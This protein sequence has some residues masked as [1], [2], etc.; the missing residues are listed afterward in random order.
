[1]GTHPWRA[2]RYAC[3]RDSR[4]A[5]LVAAGT[6]AINRWIGSWDCIDRF[7]A[8]SQFV[9]SILVRAG[10]DSDRIRVKP[11]VIGDPGLRQLPPS[12]SRTLLYVGRLSAE[13]GPELLLNAWRDACPSVPEMELVIIGDGPLRTA[14]ERDAPPRTRFLGWLDPAE[15]SKQMLGA[16]AL[17]F[18]T[19]CSENFGRSIIEAMAAGLPVLA[20][21]IATPAE[22]VGELGPRWVVAPHDQGE[23]REAL[24]GLLD[25]EAVDAGGRRGRE[26]FEQ[27][28][29]L[30]VGLRTLLG[31]YEEV[32]SRHAH[33]GGTG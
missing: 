9:R 17:I 12:R 6:I 21:D 5:S 25:D 11:N 18:P 3:Y 31:V 13:K 26:L 23:W 15:V 16:R 28:Y 33:V 2:V 27:K 4:P 22:L 10:F 7:L 1:V 24:C 14:L 19:Q 8:P 30:A 20:S 29:N 32:R